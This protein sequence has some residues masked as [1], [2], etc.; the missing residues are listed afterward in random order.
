MKRFS[1]VLLVL[2]CTGLT[3]SGCAGCGSDDDTIARSE[4]R[5]TE[6]SNERHDRNT[7]DDRDAATPGEDL[8]EAMNNLGNALEQLGQSLGGDANVEPVDYR[9]LR[10]VLPRRIRGLEKGRYNG[11][12]TSTLGIRVSTVEQEYESDDGDEWV[13]IQ[14]VDLGS[15]RNVAAFG[16]D[17]L[18]LE[19]DRESSDGFERTTTI[20]GHPALE[21]CQ[22]SGRTEQCEVHLFV[23]ERF[24][25]DLESKGFSIDRL[26]DVIDD[27]DLEDLEEMKLEGVPGS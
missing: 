25:V 13:K 9:A 17:W 23:A 20:D 6:R 18:K 10:D 22:T 11:E 7:E 14:V 19:V 26:H 21:K 3:L 4:E 24:V 16:L 12:R 15:L 2:A 1:H 5:R 27:M 8:G